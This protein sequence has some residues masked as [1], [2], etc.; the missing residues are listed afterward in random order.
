LANG[1]LFTFS[2]FLGRAKQSTPEGYYPNE[3]RPAAAADSHDWL[4]PAAAAGSHDWLLPAAATTW[5]LPAAAA[6]R[7][8]RRASAWPRRASLG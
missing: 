2:F 7:L 1:Q 8:L 3:A 5:L 4:L 6:A